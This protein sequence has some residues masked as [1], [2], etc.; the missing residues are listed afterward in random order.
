MNG[1]NTATKKGDGVVTPW[2]NLLPMTTAM[3]FPRKLLVVTAALLALGRNAWADPGNVEGDR[4]LFSEAVKAVDASRIVRA[5]LTSQELAAPQPAM[6]TLGLRN[7]AELDAKIQKGE[8]ISASE[9]EVRYYPSHEAW[10]AVA[11]WAQSQGL[12][13]DPEDGTHMSVTV[14]GQVTQ[15]AAAF[16][17]RFARVLGSDGNEYTAAVSPATVPTEIAPFIAGV[18]K[19][20][21]QN[22]IRPLT[23]Y[24]SITASNA[25]GNYGPQYLLDTYG[26]AGVGDGTGQTIAIFGFQA[27][28]S[29]TDL[30]A[31]WARIGS[32]HTLTD[33]TIINPNNYPAYNDDLSQG[34]TAGYEVTMDVEIVSGLCPGAKIRVY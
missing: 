16:Q 34:L 29:S 33:V 26:A 3:G 17:T 14:H 30:T 2:R 5:Q 4:H 12:A 10:V 25:L 19:L 22:E 7:V 18:S 8:I 1:R 13:V 23:T 31:Y 15:V 11:N 6:I 20:Q 21:P 32:P 28:P 24:Q 27:P 9:M